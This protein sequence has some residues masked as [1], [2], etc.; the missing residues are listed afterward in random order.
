M[1]G[2]Y[3]SVLQSNKSITATVAQVSIVTSPALAFDSFSAHVRYVS[4]GSSTPSGLHHRRSGHSDNCIGHD[5]LML[6]C[7]TVVLA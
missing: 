2:Q 6:P 1:S 3:P 4:S 7:N 5:A